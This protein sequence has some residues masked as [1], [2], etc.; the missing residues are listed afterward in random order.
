MRNVRPFVVGVDARPDAHLTDT[1]VGG[2][3]VHL[4]KELLVRHFVQRVFDIDSAP[5]LMRRRQHP[6]DVYM[7]VEVPGFQRAPDHA[8]VADEPVDE[9]IS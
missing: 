9:H 3:E 1:V 7:T 5:D 8:F 2:D 4:G 6:V